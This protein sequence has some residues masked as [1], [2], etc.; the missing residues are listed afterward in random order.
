MQQQQQQQQ[1]ISTPYPP[2]CYPFATPYP[3]TL[4][5]PTLP[6]PFS[7]ATPYP[8]PFPGRRHGAA[9]AIRVPIDH[10][11][12]VLPKGDSFSSSMDEIPLTD[13]LRVATICRSALRRRPRT[14]L[15]DS[16]PTMY[17]KA[18]RHTEARARPRTRREIFFNHTYGTGNLGSQH[19]NILDLHIFLDHFFFRGDHSDD[20]H[21]HACVGD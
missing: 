5:Y 17:R 1:V 19:R 4:P 10:V 18:T 2:L 14:P 13:T 11:S 7:F 3:L 12:P 8:T 16:V 15:W 20:G 6:C 9:L 21:H